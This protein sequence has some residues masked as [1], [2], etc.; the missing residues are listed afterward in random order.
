MQK[1]WFVL[2]VG[3]NREN[4]VKKQLWSRIQTHDGSTLSTSRWW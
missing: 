4:T 2:R 3:T 1:Q